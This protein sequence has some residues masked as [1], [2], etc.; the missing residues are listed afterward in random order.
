[1]ARTKLT[2]ELQQ[3]FC[4]AIASGLTYDGACDLVGLP[5][6]TFYEWVARGEGNHDRPSTPQFAE[7]ADAVKEARAKRDQKYV[8]VIEDAAAAGTW[9][10]A[11]W[12]LERTNRKDY[13]RNE[14]VEITGKDGGPVKS[15][16]VGDEQREQVTALIDELAAKR[17]KK[18]AA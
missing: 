1:M 5:R 7:F 15:Q 12:F 18:D 11:A 13:G 4:A 3:Q 6:P 9:Q 16:V 14:S 2:K 17:A 10:A 8:A